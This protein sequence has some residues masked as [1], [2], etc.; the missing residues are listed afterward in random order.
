MSDEKI[1]PC[2]CARLTVIATRLRDWLD[3]P[4]GKRRDETLE[5]LLHVM[6]EYRDGGCHPAGDPASARDAGAPW[7]PFRCTLTLAFMLEDLT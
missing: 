3:M 4:P 6:R 1:T 5:N 7:E 2:E